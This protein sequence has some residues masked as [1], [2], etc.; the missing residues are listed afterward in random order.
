MT[1]TIEISEPSR[2]P[3]R[4]YEMTVRLRAGDAS[5][6]GI[7]ATRILIETSGSGLRH[8]PYDYDGPMNPL[9]HPK[10]DGHE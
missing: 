1:G 7:L 3:G 9:T 6:L 8:V 5:S 10:G 2:G 4:H